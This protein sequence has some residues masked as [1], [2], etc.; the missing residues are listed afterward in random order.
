MAGN[1]TLTTATQNL[2][3]AFNLVN[4]TLQYINGQFTS[5][6]YPAAG[7]SIVKIFHGRSRVTAVTILTTGGTV[8]LYDSSDPALIPASSQKL[9][10]DGT[11]PL[12]VY[13]AGIEFT[14][15]IILVVNAPTQAT[16]TYSVY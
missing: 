7:L 13:Q 9:Y 4:K 5:S 11:A 3:V 15:G 14:N 10:L 16:V 2:V 8:E 6:A 1:D 12:G